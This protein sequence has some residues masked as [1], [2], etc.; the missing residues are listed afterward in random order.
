MPLVDL[1]TPGTASG[2]SLACTSSPDRI[3]KIRAFY[4]FAVDLGDYLGVS[5]SSIESLQ[6][7][8]ASGGLLPVYESGLTGKD[9]YKSQ[10]AA[11]IKDAAEAVAKG[12]KA[13]WS[14]TFIKTR[15]AWLTPFPDSF[16]L[17]P[18]QLRINGKM[19]RV[20]G[21]LT[22][23]EF[24]TI[25]AYLSPDGV[26]SLTVS[27]RQEQPLGLGDAIQNLRVLRGYA[28]KMFSQHAT[29]LVSDGSAVRS[30]LESH[31]F[32]PGSEPIAEKVRSHRSL[33][34]ESFQCPSQRFCDAHRV[35]DNPAVAGLMN[36]A[37]WYDT[38]HDQYRERL[39]SK[40]FGYRS[41]ELYLVDRD[42]TLCV[43]EGFWKAEDPL[44][45]YMGNVLQAMEYHVALQALLRGQL[46]YARKLY[47][48]S[49][50]SESILS[51]V[52]GVRRSRA[53]LSGAYESLNY[54][55]LVLH[56]FTRR[57]LRGLDEESEIAGILEDVERRV[58]NVSDAVSL[59]A[60]VTT[61]QTSE[62]LQEFGNGINKKVLLATIVGAVAGVLALVVTL[63]ALLIPRDAASGNGV[64]DVH[65]G[66][67]GSVSPASPP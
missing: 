53:I 60:S 46:Q 47:S 6:E 5:D 23:W 21:S 31:G 33:F 54:S 16:Q 19:E 29:A 40:E 37:T 41:N 65:P 10:A 61:S 26:V 49:T 45:L 8:R 24:D 36:L 27:F 50:S 13:V 28:K 39:A 25:R 48:T 58:E 64:G 63:V 42:T 38:Y 67:S 56:G 7:V 30:V 1:P 4:T 12:G 3:S 14:D 18:E 15:A 11:I 44:H 57:L 51:S 55:V 9:G 52:E 34:V 20:D 66:T 43:Q 2:V 17:G 32:A 59:Q 22:G 35:R 62:K